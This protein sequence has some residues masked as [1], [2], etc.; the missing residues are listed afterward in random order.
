M[1]KNLLFLSDKLPKPN[2]EKHLKNNEG[3]T[4]I[5]VQSYRSYQ[6]EEK[7]KEKEEI[8][9]IN[10]YN[11]I[12]NPGYNK[13]ISNSP[14]SNK[15]LEEKNNSLNNRKVSL[16]LNNKIVIMPPINQHHRLLINHNLP[17]IVNYDKLYINKNKKSIQKELVSLDIIAKQKNELSKL[18]LNNNSLNRKLNYLNNKGYLNPAQMKDIYKIYPYINRSLPQKGMNSNKVR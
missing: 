12:H 17:K 5:K 2:Y 7:E 11:S 14:S 9:K 18:M 8:P 1:P 10:Q 16:I 13:E 4:E 3:T 15:I 6:N